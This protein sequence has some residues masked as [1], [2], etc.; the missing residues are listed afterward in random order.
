MV[1][2]A[3]DAVEAGMNPEELSTKDRASLGM[4]LLKQVA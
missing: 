1:G 4:A 3:L 2:A